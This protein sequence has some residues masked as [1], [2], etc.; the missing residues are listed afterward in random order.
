M[1]SSSIARVSE[2]AS[3][4]VDHFQQLY[5]ADPDPWKFVSS[6]Y[7]QRKYEASL[8][9]LG[10]RRFHRALEVGCS[11]GVL[12]ERLAGHCDQLTA[13]DFAP[14]AVEAAALRCAAY[15]W[16]RIQ[17]MQAPRQW[18]ED[19]FD[20]IV[21]SEVLYFFATSDLLQI[22][23]RTLRSILPGGSVLLVNYTGTTD[24]PHSGDGAADFFIETTA[25]HLKPTLQRREPDYRL[26]LLSK[27][28]LDQ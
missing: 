22:C 17:Q 13:I 6:A 20:L 4:T 23:Q 2:S 14:L 27:S 8:A 3:R 1:K 16:V 11:I 7:E 28:T 24:D 19:S 25:P 10:G 9:A 12:T 15:P 18:P 26:D 21:L 5:N